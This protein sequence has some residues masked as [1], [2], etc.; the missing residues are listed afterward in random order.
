MDNFNMEE[1]NQGRRPAD[2]E[3]IKRGSFW[4]G[5]ATGA[6]VGVVVTVM[7]CTIYNM[8]SVRNE[9]IRQAKENPDNAMEV[10]ESTKIQE[11]M[12]AIGKVI[13]EQYYKPIDPDEMEKYIYKG[14]MAGTGDAY[15]SYMSAEE[16]EQ[17]VENTQ[18]TFCGVGVTMQY[19]DS[20]G[21]VK[22]ISLTE[23]GAASQADVKV[24]DYIYMVDG[25]KYTIVNGDT[26][27]LVSKVRGDE[28]TKV[29]LTLLRTM[30][31]GKEKEIT[32]ELTRKP[33][34]VETVT[35]QMLQ[36]KI[37]YIQITQFEGTTLSQ[38]EKAYKKLQ[39]DGAK[40]LIVDL[41]GN[42]GG[43]V[44]TT[45]SIVDYF[46]EEDL[47]T[48]LEDKNGGRFEYKN[49]DVKPWGKP[50]VVLVD[51]NSASASEIFAGAIR[52]YEAGTLMGTKTFGKGIV[53]HLVYLADG[54]ALNLTFAKYYTPD[55]E[56][57][58]EI[59]IEPDMEVKYEAP[60]QGETYSVEK[61]NQVLAAI[62]Q[63]KSEMS[64]Q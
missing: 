50:L 53:Q 46:V 22:I 5:I 62:K 25:E 15:S 31:D 6:F 26:T 41:R 35:S 24:G 17:Y 18:G 43:Q 33:I 48:Y 21:L 38:F 2:E 10:A 45:A 37:G 30:D 36:D 61:D 32:V 47:I 4:K 14:M 54:S 59:G 28:G 34:E 42:P 8:A 57:I 19:D 27:E 64:G 3:A 58:H 11:K 51:G 20:K 44:E 40:G 16:L 49:G 13:D 29:S 12:K 60:A 23:G 52:D 9:Q 56:N 63:I 7:G 55:G 39:S 1:Y